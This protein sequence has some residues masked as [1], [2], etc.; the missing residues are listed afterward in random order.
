MHPDEK[1][2]KVASANPSL[3]TYQLF[4]HLDKAHLI[5]VGRLGQFKFP[6]GNYVY[7]GSARRNLIAR[8]KRHLRKEKPLRWHIDYLLVA[9]GA[10]VVNIKLSDRT[11]CDWNQET[12]GEILMAGFGASDCMAGCSSHLKYQGEG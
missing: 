1:W 12:F 11:E 9:D 5:T 4:I 3:I 8:V 6:A 7:T 2:I 10:Q